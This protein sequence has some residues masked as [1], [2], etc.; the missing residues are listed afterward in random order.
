MYI[1]VVGGGRLGYYLSKALLSQGHEV[2][3]IEK[4]TVK[5]ERIEEELGSICMQGDGCETAVLE[6]AGTER[7]DLLVAVTD[8][9]EDNLVACQVAKHKFNVP[10]II[11]RISNPKNEALFKKLGIDVTI[12]STNLILEYIGQ[13]VPAY[14]VVHLL[15]L[16]KTKLELIEVKISAGSP[17]VGK[18]VKDIPLPPGSLLI[19]VIKDEDIKLPAQDTVLHADDRVLAVTKIDTEQDLRAV[20][21][22]S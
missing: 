16:R 9:D 19:L 12:S 22:G 18:K 10:R 20:L 21:A 7:A 14:P 5:V 8:E 1:I 2:L 17:A 15:E 3:V 4:D 13:E 11:A 6:E